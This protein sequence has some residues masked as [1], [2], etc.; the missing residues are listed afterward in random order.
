MISIPFLLLTF[1]FYAFIPELHRNVSG[2]CLMAF[3]SSL[4]FLFTTLT[5]VSAIYNFGDFKDFPLTCNVLAYVSYFF[6]ILCFFWQNV[7]CFEIWK[8][9]RLKINRKFLKY[10][11]Y[12][13]TC[14]TLMTLLIFLIDT[15]E[16]FP[17]A[18]QPEFGV[19]KCFLKIDFTIEAIYLYI[20]VAIITAADLIFLIVAAMKFWRT[21]QIY[22][23]L[24]SQV[25][26]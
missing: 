1:C 26:K 3:V 8:S 12:A 24:E 10:C 5:I 18:F 9:S 2:K 16:P 7:M 15:L 21:K 20:P 14:P 6:M 11:V 17:L 19:D 25:S 22:S 23:L 13:Y 4:F